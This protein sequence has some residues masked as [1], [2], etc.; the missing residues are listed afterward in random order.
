MAAGAGYLPPVATQEQL[1]T[2]LIDKLVDQANEIHVCVVCGE[3]LIRGEQFVE[4]SDQYEGK[5]D[6][7]LVALMQ[8]S[9]L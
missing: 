2:A 7:P 3:D 8:A 6:C 9:S 1:V 4:H 5:Y